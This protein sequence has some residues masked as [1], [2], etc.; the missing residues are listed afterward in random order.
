[1]D[2]LDV[3]YKEAIARDDIRD[4]RDTCSYCRHSRKDHCKGGVVHGNY[5]DQMRNGS[6]PT[7]AYLLHLS[8]RTGSM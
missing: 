4:G 3:E 1:V 8:L 2:E 6:A 5:K 7:V